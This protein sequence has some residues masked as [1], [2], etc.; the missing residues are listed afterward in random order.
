MHDTGQVV[1]KCSECPNVIAEGRVV[2]SPQCAGMRRGRKYRGTGHR[3]IRTRVNG[4]QVYL[5]RFIYEQE[6]GPIPEK[7][8]VHHRD[9]D[10]FNNSLDNL[11]L[12]TQAEH[13]AAHDYWR[14]RRCYG[15]IDAELGF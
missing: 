1:L 7:A 2:C 3:H 5:H 9:G 8:V 6:H 10:R 11:E 4:A 13:L 12:L 15:P 14:G